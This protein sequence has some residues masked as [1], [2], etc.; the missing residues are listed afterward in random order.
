MTRQARIT[1][2]NGRSVILSD[3]AADASGGVSYTAALEF[4]AGEARIVVWDYG[5]ARLPGVL[6]R[7]ADEWRGFDGA[8]EFS[9]LEGQFAL[10]LT[11]DGKGTI[12][13]V[14]TVSQPWPPCWSTTIEL[15]FGAG[16]NA[17]QIATDVE[18]FFGPATK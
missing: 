14:A 15:S 4:E 2:E 18:A 16:S 10:T 11:H 17:D 6:R 5:P 9:S 3:L 1:G 12:A 7:A 8:L 13:C